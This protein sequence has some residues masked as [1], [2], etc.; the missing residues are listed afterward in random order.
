MAAE[1]R[2]LIVVGASAGGVP[3]LV[4]LVRGLGADLPA[5]MLVVLHVPA[6][7][8]SFLPSILERAGQLPARHA[9]DGDP[10]A[11]GV[12]SVAPPG[13]HLVLKDERLRLVHGPQQNGRRPSIDALFRS[14]ACELG[15]RAIGVVLSGLLDDG[16]A[17]LAAIK[18]RGGIAIVQDPKEA[19]YPDMPRNALLNVPVDHVLPVSQM[20]SCLRELL[21]ADLPAVESPAVSAALAYETAA[22]R[23]EG[24]PMAMPPGEP[25]T[26]TCPDCGGALWES[27]GDAPMQFRCYTGHAYGPSSLEAMQRSREESVLWR[28]LRVLE[29]SAHLTRT[30]A[31]RMK[32]RG[33]AI[34]A[35]RYRQRA[36][37]ALETAEVLRAILANRSAEAVPSPAPEVD[38]GADAED[39]QDLGS[40]QLEP[41]EGT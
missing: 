15:R 13:L 34:T 7:S 23:L 14:A 17:G 33:N 22:D 9:E 26:F 32:D 24:A 8:R 38:L 25:T 10:L 29:E 41:D 5:A 20:G 28:G 30:L 40:R 39:N 4:E 12:I 19:R 2:E 21:A 6:V 37:D 31:E 16:T 18:R 3:A 11:R 36:A 35:E 27:R 1:R